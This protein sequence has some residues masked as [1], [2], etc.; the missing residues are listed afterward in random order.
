VG[1]LWGSNFTDGGKRERSNS[2]KGLI[3]K[4]SSCGLSTVA[5]QC[6]IQES[7]PFKRPVHEDIDPE[8][9]LRALSVVSCQ[10]KVL[11]TEDISNFLSHLSCSL[12]EFSPFDGLL[13]EEKRQLILVYVNYIFFRILPKFTSLV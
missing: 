12:E 10:S 9:R 5:E 11:A 7:R 6:S 8:L 1:G 3:N 13:L 4:T 2:L